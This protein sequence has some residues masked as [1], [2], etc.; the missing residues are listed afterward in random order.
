MLSALTQLPNPRARRGLRYQF[1]RLVLIMLCSVLAGAKTLVEMAEWAADTT[2]T[3]LAA[4]GIDTP[5]ATTLARVF[6]RLD[7]D[8][9]VL[10]AADWA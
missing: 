10:L 1:A 9:F 3:E 2:R 5:H 6:E 8:A 7:S 4:R